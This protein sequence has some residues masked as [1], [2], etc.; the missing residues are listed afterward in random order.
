[1]Q[2]QGS[3]ILGQKKRKD[4]V[5][6]KN[7][8]EI[9]AHFRDQWNSLCSSCLAFDAGRGWEAARI[10]AS[11]HIFCSSSGQDSLLSLVDFSRQFGSDFLDT[12]S[13]I[14]G[15]N[16]LDDHPMVGMMLSGE[17]AS[18]INFLD[19]GPANGA[20]WTKF[21]NW[22]G[23]NPVVRFAQ[24]N[25]RFMRSDVI[26]AVRN[27]EGGGHVDVDV[28]LLAD[29]LGDP[30]NAGWVANVN[31]L[32]KPLQGSILLSSVRQ[33]GHE[34]LRTIQNHAPD[35]VSTGISYPPKLEA[36]SYQN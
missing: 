10:A 32:E 22:W 21:S 16:L 2:P 23:H 6:Q 7:Q 34:L 27:K 36:V 12:C 24:T 4:I 35:L 20:N 13:P 1:M 30:N 28:S 11:V 29:R 5:R 9:R 14:S 3:F 8:D 15:R 19:S 18:F 33:I 17:A 26:S 25:R 31:G